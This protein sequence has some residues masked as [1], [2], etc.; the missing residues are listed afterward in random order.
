MPIGKM[1]IPKTV[2]GYWTFTNFTSVLGEN[3]MKIK[4][5]KIRILLEMLN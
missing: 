1:L 3:L 5:N 2:S 4:L